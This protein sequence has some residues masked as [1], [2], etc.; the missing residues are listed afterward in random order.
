M[1]TMVHLRMVDSRTSRS[2]L[3]QF[4]HVMPRMRIHGWLL[5]RGRLRYWYVVPF[6]LG[7]RGG[8]GHQRK[9]GDRRFEQFHRLLSSN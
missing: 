9:Q 4:A 6:M 2:R 7:K 3:L 1:R 5:P 8:G